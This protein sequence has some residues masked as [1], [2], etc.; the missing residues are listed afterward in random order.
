MV[1]SSIKGHLRVRCRIFVPLEDN[2]GITPL[3]VSGV[4]NSEQVT[5]LPDREIITPVNADRLEECLSG[6]DPEKASYL[7][8]GFRHGF[9]FHFEGYTHQKFCNN[10]KSALE[11][12]EIIDKKLGKELLASRIAGPFKIVPY[13]HFHISPLGVVP[14]KNPGE[15]RLIH[16]LSSPEG[17]SVNDGI[18]STYSS[19]QYHNIQNA[20][21][22]LKALPNPFMAKTDIESAFR[23]IPIHPS[24]RHLLGFTWKGQFY[25]DR[26]L[27]MGLAESCRIFEEFSSKGGGDNL[28]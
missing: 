5:D 22:F 24:Q 1:K 23:I 4:I 11:H 25:F 7:V 19:V 8:N 10:L 17:D 27:P 9:Q 2:T 14:K 15:F 21:S 20:I 12:P 28:P 16:H 3:P 26:C 18:D 6:Y 13:D